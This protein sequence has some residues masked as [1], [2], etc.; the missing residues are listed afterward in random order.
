MANKTENDVRVTGYV[1]GDPE[2]RFTPTGAA[3]TNFNLSTKSAWKDAGGEWQEDTQWHAAVAW[4]EAAER[5]NELVQ[6]GDLVRISG[7]LQTRSWHDAEHDITRYKTEIRVDR[8]TLMERAAERPARDPGAYNP[9][10]APPAASS[11][12]QRQQA[13]RPAADRQQPAQRA[14]QQAAPYRPSGPPP[15]QRK[16]VTDEDDLPF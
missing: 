4:N 14:G 2:M 5:I 13:G 16:Q 3:V 15:S 8:W 7:R 6:K 12:P 10:P 11:A 9:A 1:G